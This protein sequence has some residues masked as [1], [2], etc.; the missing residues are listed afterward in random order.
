[1]EGKEMRVA[2]LQSYEG[3]PLRGKEQQAQMILEKVTAQL[4]SKGIMYWLAAGTA[5]GFCRDKGFIPSDT[6]IDIEMLEGEQNFN[7]VAVAGEL[8]GGTPVRLSGDGKGTI[9]QLAFQFPNNIL[10]D[11]HFYRLEDDKLISWSEVSGDIWYPA[12]FLETMTSVPYG[13]KTYPC[14]NPDQYLEWMYGPGWKTPKEK[15]A[16]WKPL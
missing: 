13:G 9:T 8:A 6:D 7:A 16:V 14:F 1:M 12:S 4:R 5:L 11:V 10:F 3:L 2:I 15:K